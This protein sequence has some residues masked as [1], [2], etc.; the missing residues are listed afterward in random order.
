MRTAFFWVILQQVVVT[1][2]VSD[3]FSLRYDPE[4]CSSHPLHG[5]SL[6]SHILERFQQNLVFGI[7]VVHSYRNLILIITGPK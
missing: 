1:P 2:H 4:E 3:T 5:R 6:K 7:Y